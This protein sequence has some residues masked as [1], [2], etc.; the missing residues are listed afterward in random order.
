MF[1][2]DI[3]RN[4]LTFSYMTAEGDEYTIDFYTELLDFKVPAKKLLELPATY[5]FVGS[6]VALL[7]KRAKDLEID[8]EAWCAEEDDKLREQGMK[9]ETGIKHQ[10]RTRPTW[11]VQKRNINEA[12]IKYFQ[13]KSLHEAI[14]LRYPILELIKTGAITHSEIANSMSP[15][16]VRQL[17]GQAKRFK[18]KSFN[19]PS[20]M[21]MERGGKRQLKR[22]KVRVKPRMEE[23]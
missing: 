4:I 21:S 9:R 23:D 19:R 18:G 15:E 16:P 6:V 2:K 5:G 1:D 11:A 7:M 14:A 8:F 20:S 10:I 3:L 22:N 12:W 17:R 13:A